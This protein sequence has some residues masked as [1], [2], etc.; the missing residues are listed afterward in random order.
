MPD[1]PK[2]ADRETAPVNELELLAEDGAS[3]GGVLAWLWDM[4]R[5]W[6]PAL[7]AVL[8]IRSAIAE[9][10]RIP[11]GSM[12]PTLAIGDHI[13]VSK[14]S[15]GL[16]IPF[17]QIELL[18]LGEPE[19]GD[20][21][22]FRYPPDPSLDYIKRIVG[23]PGD[24]VEVRNGVVYV[25]GQEARRTY[26][27]RFKFVNDR[28]QVQEER[29]YDEDLL[30]VVHPVLASVGSSGIRRNYGP[31]TVPEG[32]YFVMGDNRDNSAD[33]RVWGFVPRENIKGK[34]IWVWLSVDRCN[35]SIPII[36]SFRPGRFGLRV[37]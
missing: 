22:V 8:V 30:G 36:G 16:R 29:L 26:R 35:G 31:R 19:R 21:I 9:P 2:P 25:N 6:G 14:F 1:T 11:S 37:R 4:L 27:D 12:V 15:Y 13:L 17:T 32:H 10:F 33:S 7:L 20:V 5:T 23:L 34:A 24:T 18:P 3:S 28:C